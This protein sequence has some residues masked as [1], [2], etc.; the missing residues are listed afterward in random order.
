MEEYHIVLLARNRWCPWDK[1]SP[2]LS[3]QVRISISGVWLNRSLDIPAVLLPSVPSG[4]FLRHYHSL[5]IDIRILAW[6][7]TSVCKNDR[8]RV[9]RF[10]LTAYLSSPA[11]TLLPFWRRIWG[12]LCRNRALLLDGDFSLR[13]KGTRNYRSDRLRDGCRPS[14]PCPCRLY[15]CPCL[16]QHHLRLEARFHLL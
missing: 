3:K 10:A 11:S 9:L 5:H 1:N 16:N 7:S 6:F 2:L 13:R 8:A 12:R 14:C 4:G 15:R